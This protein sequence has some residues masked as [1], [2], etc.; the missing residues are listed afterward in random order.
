[1]S[2]VHPVGSGSED[3]HKGFFSWVSAY[4]NGSDIIKMIS[5][6]AVCFVVVVVYKKL[7]TCKKQNTTFQHSNTIKQNKTKQNKVSV[8]CLHF[9]ANV[10]Q[11]P[12]DDRR[13][14]LTFQ[15]WAPE[16]QKEIHAAYTVRL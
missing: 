11:I 3:E 15:Y 12:D 8:L 4:F 9:F 2:L 16:Q 5:S 1:M 13:A 6:T 14:V 10:A 7:K